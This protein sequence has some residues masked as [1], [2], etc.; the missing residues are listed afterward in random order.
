MTCVA[1]WML[2]SFHSTNLPFIQILPVPGNAITAP[3]ETILPDWPIWRSGEL[4]IYW[5]S[6]QKG[7]RSARACRG[8]RQ[9]Q[10]NRGAC[11]ESR[12]FTRTCMSSLASSALPLGANGTGRTGVL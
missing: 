10:Q 1:M 8:L 4:V 9:C 7:Q 11:D 3:Y 12:A 6:P 2:A 5:D